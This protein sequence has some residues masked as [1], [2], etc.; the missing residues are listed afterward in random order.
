MN[1][2][3]QFAGLSAEAGTPAAISLLGFA[4]VCASG[5]HRLTASEALN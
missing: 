2:C 4:A 5:L 1:R 3:D